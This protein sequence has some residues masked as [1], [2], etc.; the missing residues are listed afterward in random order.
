MVGLRSP[1]AVRSRVA[2]CEFRSP[3]AA[4]AAWLNKTQSCRQWHV[5][6][7]TSAPCIP[8]MQEV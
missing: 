1:V 8:A 5:R 4:A 6:Y 2:G 7:E 3:C